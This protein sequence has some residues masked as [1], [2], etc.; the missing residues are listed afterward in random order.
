MDL[1]S[2]TLKSSAIIA[3]LGRQVSVIQEAQSPRVSGSI[4]TGGDI[5][6]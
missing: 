2:L 5:F 1:K 4:P 3:Q 6:C